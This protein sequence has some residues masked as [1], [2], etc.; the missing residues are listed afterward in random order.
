MNLSLR[1]FEAQF[2]SSLSG[3]ARCR[4]AMASNVLCVCAL[5]CLLSEL[6]VLSVAGETVNIPYAV[7]LP[8]QCVALCVFAVP[9][10]DVAYALLMRFVCGFCGGQRIEFAAA[11]IEITADDNRYERAL[12]I[13]PRSAPSWSRRA[14]ST[15][16]TMRIRSA[17]SVHLSQM[18]AA[19][20]DACILRHSMHR[21][22]FCCLFVEHKH[23]D[24]QT[25][26]VRMHRI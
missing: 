6:T 8:F 1:G 3:I 5:N 16:R 26:M 2:A 9:F 20:M 7:A 19:R 23:C 15:R 10:A 17:E 21:C 4:S 13:C 11:D 25:R 12:E 24:V 22:C 18:A 14:R